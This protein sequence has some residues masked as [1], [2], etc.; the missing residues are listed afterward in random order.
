MQIFCY[1]KITDYND[2]LLCEDAEQAAVY[3]SAYHIEQAFTA[4]FK[5]GTQM[6]L[7]IL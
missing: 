7:E 5:V 1:L 2:R 3:E 6:M 4:G